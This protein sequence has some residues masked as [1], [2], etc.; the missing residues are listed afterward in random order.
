MNDYKTRVSNSFNFTYAG[1]CNVFITISRKKYLVSCRGF[2]I[3]DDIV[4][5]NHLSINK[6]SFDSLYDA[7]SEF[8]L[9]ISKL[10][11]SMDWYTPRYFED[12]Y[13]FQKSCLKELL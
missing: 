9:I 8:N 4:F 5:F 10:V 2:E 3:I 7:I 6:K 12:T 1:A 13:E 11:E